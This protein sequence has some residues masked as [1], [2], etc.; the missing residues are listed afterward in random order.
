M[1]P[2]KFPGTTFSFLPADI[3]V[4]DP[5]FRPAGA[6]RRAGHRQQ[7]D[8]QLRLRHRSAQAH[9]HGRRH[10]RRC[11][12]SRCSTIR[13]ST[14]TSIARSPAQV[15]L[16]QR[17]IANNLLITLSGSQQ[18]HAEFLAQPGERRLLSDRRADAAI[19]GRHAVRI[20]STCRSRRRT[21][22]RRN[23]SAASRTITPGPSPA[24]VSHYNVQPVIDIYGAVQGRDLGAVSRRH[25]HASCSETA[26]GRAARLPC[27]DRAGR[28]RR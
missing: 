19:P 13:R 18:V 4:A 8:G 2:Q 27:R 9:P 22:R 28:C 24:V 7:P 15:G 26:Q 11:A 10:R 16:T 3:V 17:D 21:A 25:R 20:S 1:L 6:D 5:Q 23:I 14:S 12:S